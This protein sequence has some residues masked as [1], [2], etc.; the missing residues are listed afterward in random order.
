MK[1]KSP[2]G[3]M[4]RSLIFPGLGQWYNNKKIKAFLVFCAQSGLLAN[5][6][7]LNQKYVTS[8]TEFERNFYINNRNLSVWWLVGT[9][10]FSMADAFVDAHLADFD[11]SPD[12]SNLII[13]PTIM[14]GDPGIPVSFCFRF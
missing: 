14:T 7:Y 5:S 2:T 4:I 3:A 6:I 10:L 9:T 13:H 11:E 1:K 8:S 12:L